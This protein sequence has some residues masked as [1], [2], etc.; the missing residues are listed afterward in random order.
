MSIRIDVDPANPGQFFACCGLLE[1][2]DRL[3]PETEGW[4]EERTFYLGFPDGSARRVE[5]LLTALVECPIDSISEEGLSSKTAPLQLGPPLCLRL[6]WWLGNDGTPNLFKTWAANATSHQ[7]FCKWREPLKGKLER[8]AIEPQKLLTVADRIQGSYGLD[9]DLGWDAPNVGFSLNEHAEL[10][11]LPTRPAVEL[12]GA[13]GLQRFFPIL[14][15]RKQA[16]QYASWCIPLGAPVAGVAAAGR[17]AVVVRHR[18]RTQ[19]V[20]R[21][22]FKGLDRATLIQGEPNA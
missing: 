1:L 5:E 9:S 21:G 10:K 22:N 18:F 3:W 4:F 13:I 17:V 12:L 6:N 11:Q 2:A 20:Y 14:D 19:F 16:V 8:I 15:R 7:M